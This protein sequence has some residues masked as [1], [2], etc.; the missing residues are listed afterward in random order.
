MRIVVV[1]A[2]GVGAAIARAAATRDFFESMLI[3]DVD[4]SRARA[5]ADRVDDR[6]VSA[7]ALDASSADAVTP[8]LRAER[9]DWVVNAADPRANEAIF[10]GAF[11]AGANYVDMAMTLSSPHPV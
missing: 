11:A 2:G 4:A 8:L 5:V 7:G 3:V 10:D 6:R 9:A 1:G